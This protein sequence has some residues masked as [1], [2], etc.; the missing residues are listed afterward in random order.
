MRWWVGSSRAPGIRNSRLRTG[1]APGEGGAVQLAEERPDG[2]FQLQRLDPSAQLPGRL[3]PVSTPG[4]TGRQASRV[5]R[6]HLMRAGRPAAADALHQMDST[7]LPKRRRD[8]RCSTARHRS[9]G[10]CEPLSSKEELTFQL[11]VH[12]HVD[13]VDLSLVFA[14]SRILQGQI[15]PPTPDLR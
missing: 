4:G 11:G 13:A 5:R 10:Q 14:R 6:H 9:G 12:V 8:P 2:K 7:R 15:V 1:R 3:W